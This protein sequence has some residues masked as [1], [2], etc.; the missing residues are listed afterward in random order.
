MTRSV[1]T[2]LTLMVIITGVSEDVVIYLKW[3]SLY[4]C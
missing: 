1:T 4:Y 3:L 2:E